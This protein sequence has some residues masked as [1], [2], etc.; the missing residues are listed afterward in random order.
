MEQVVLG[1]KVLRTAGA[2]C[3][4]ALGLVVVEGNRLSAN[5]R[6]GVVDDQGAGP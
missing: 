5:W 3:A 1:R 2:A 4:K 6:W